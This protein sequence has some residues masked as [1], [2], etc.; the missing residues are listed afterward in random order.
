MTRVEVP[1]EGLWAA[2]VRPSGVGPFRAGSRGW[3]AAFGPGK[4]GATVFS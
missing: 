2:C 4:V 3:Y 1:R